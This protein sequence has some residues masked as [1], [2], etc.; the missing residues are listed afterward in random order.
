ML[1]DLDTESFNLALLEKQG[2]RLMQNENTLC[3]K[4]M[5]A[6]YF[7]GTDFMNADIGSNPSLI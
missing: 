7:S 1:F 3:H 2:W 4:V 5:K 6:R